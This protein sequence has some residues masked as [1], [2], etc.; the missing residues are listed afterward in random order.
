MPGGENWLT[1]A[2]GP[3]DEMLARPRRAHPRPGICGRPGCFRSVRRRMVSL[4][5]GI[6]GADP[7]LDVVRGWL[8]DDRVRT[9]RPNV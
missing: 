7:N 9:A 6:R 3:D 2:S 5:R 4:D 8:L 1:R